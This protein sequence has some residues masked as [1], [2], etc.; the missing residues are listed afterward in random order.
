MKKKFLYI[1][2]LMLIFSIMNKNICYIS[3]AASSVEKNQKSGEDLEIESQSTQEDI[4]LKQDILVEE[5]SKES[6]EERNERLASKSRYLTNK[7]SYMEVVLDVEDGANITTQLQAAFLLAATKATKEIPYKVVIP[8]GTYH[9]SST[10]HIYS[11]TSLSIK[12]VILVRDFQEG[13]ML[14]SGNFMEGSPYIEQEQNII[15]QGGTFDGNCFDTLY[16]AVTTSFSNLYFPYAKN[17]QLIGV[18][19]CNNMGGHHVEMNGV[20]NVIIR[21]CV[22]S[23]YYTNRSVTDSYKREALKFGTMEL[24]SSDGEKVKTLTCNRILIQNN[25]F[26]DVFQG[27]GFDYIPGS[28]VYKNVS[29]HNNTFVS[30]RRE[31]MIVSSLSQSNISRNRIENVRTGIWIQ[32]INPLRESKK[33]DCKIWQNNSKKE[34][35]G[36]DLKIYPMILNSYGL[37]SQ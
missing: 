34:D 18:K 15:I 13:P 6:E 20:D 29:I 12:D 17:I 10:I 4:N 22:F 2:F 14:M 8:E 26:R 7:G 33:L 24:V 21:D 32:S 37:L 16:G 25:T 23:K 11:N 36:L 35:R 19:I 3:S 28:K 1:L 9:L 27:I 5:N 31:A 30:C